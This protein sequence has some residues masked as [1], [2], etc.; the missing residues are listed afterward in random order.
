[1]TGEDVI[2]EVQYKYSEHIEMSQNPDAF[3]S[4]I[5]ANKIVTLKDYID[6]LEKR[7]E[8]NAEY[9]IRH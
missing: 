1:M 3:V 6:Y 8:K 7:I 9:T 4:G 5:L 2:R